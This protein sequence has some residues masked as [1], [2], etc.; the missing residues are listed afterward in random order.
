MESGAQPGNDNAAKGTRWRNAIDKALRNRC[1]SDGQKA[2]VDL[3]EVMLTAAENGEAWALKELG[4]RLDGKAPQSI[5]LGNP[6][7][8]PLELI[9][10]VTL[11]KSDE[12]S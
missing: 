8:T 3:A 11:V 2:L 12:S 6:D 4:D 9:G 5:G 1:K 7:G 10:K